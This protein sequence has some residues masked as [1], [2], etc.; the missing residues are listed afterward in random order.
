MKWIKIPLCVTLLA[1]CSLFTPKDDM[2]SSIQMYPTFDSAY[3]TEQFIRTF[4][5]SE[6]GLIR[7]DLLKRRNEYLS[8]SLGL[9]MLFLVNEGRSDEFAAQVKVLR[10]YFLHESGMVS[11]ELKGNTM[12]I[13][14]NPTNAWIDDARICR[15][16]IRAA[17]T[18]STPSYA[19]LA[20]EIQSALDSYS[21]VDGLPVD[22]T[23]LNTK[24]VGSRVTLSYL[25]Y[26][27]LNSLSNER[28]V[29]AKRLLENAPTDGPFYA[30]YYDTQHK[31]Y[32]FDNTINL[33]DQL[34]VALR[35]EQFGLNTTEFFTFLVSELQNGIVY[36]RYD[37]RT[38]Q[39][40]VQYESQA[41]YA[42][43][44]FYLMERNEMTLA[45]ETLEHL[46]ELSVQDDA[47]PYYGGYID[48]ITK[49]THSFDNLLPLLAERRIAHGDIAP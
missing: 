12:S 22:F 13:E 29:A 16:L 30:K 24:E 8:E 41:V 45:T 49:E 19:L 44:I 25:D 27:M 9:Y 36:G 15:A 39:P 1:G 34:Y 33:I 46:Y 40:V 43:V 47:S 10:H 4:L 20:E 31:T 35:Y 6:Q 17:E 2:T 7:T 11:W 5:L 14:A 26:D 23:D 32:H 38:E 42:L 18:F 28:V 37:R 3:P 21:F 48:V